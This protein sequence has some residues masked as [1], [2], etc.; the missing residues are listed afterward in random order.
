MRKALHLSIAAMLT[1]ANAAPA[2]ACD[3]CAIQNANLSRIGQAGTFELGAAEQYTQFGTLQEEGREISNGANQKLKSSITQAFLR[4]N[5]TDRI[6]LQATLPFISRSYRRLEEGEIDRGDV[7]GIG[8]A[9]LLASYLLHR[10]EGA[11]GT[12][13]WRVFGGLK[14]PTGDAE[15]LGEEAAEGH[16]QDE[17]GA[18]EEHD[19]HSEPDEQGEAAGDQHEA[20]GPG[21][22]AGEEPS[23]IH[24]HDLALGS[25]S[26]DYVVG[27]Q[28]FV[29]AGRAFAAAEVQYAIRTEGGFGYRYANDLL[30]NAGPGMFLLTQDEATVSLR[31]NLSGEYKEKDVFRG[32]KVGDTALTSLFLG[33]ELLVTLGSNMSGLL[34]LDLPLDID[35]SGVQ[36]VPDYRLRVGITARF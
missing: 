29:R 5:A 24:G 23:G 31:A 19:E 20:E 21:H 33:P 34:G 32:Y 9:S 26:L 1:L 25:G 7:T 14:F 12:F 15:R 30:W 28:V 17:P 36:I 35:N 3:P 11:D 27:T 16:H 13:Y 6:G 22:H 10:G 2:S 18:R 4:Y 8:D